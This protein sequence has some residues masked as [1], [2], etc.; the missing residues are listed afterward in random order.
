MTRANDMSNT[1]LLLLTKDANEN[2]FS[3][4][5][6]MNLPE[7][8]LDFDL[9]DTYGQSLNSSYFPENKIISDSGLDATNKFFFLHLNIRSLSKN[10]DQFHEFINELK[11]ESAIIGISE[12]WL[13]DVP[14]TLF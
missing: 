3:Q 5:L 12:T 14:P 2:V 13:K 9:N 4:T 6:N 8:H 11:F 1:F 7:L 10:F